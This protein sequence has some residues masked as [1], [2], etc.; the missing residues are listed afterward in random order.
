MIAIFLSKKHKKIVIILI[1]SPIPI[2][3]I[4]KSIAINWIIKVILIVTNQHLK[5]NTI[6]FNLQSKQTTTDSHI[7]YLF[8]LLTLLIVLFKPK[9]KMSCNSLEKT[10]SIKDWLKQALHAK[11]IHKLIKI[12]IVIQT[13]LQGKL[14]KP[15]ELIL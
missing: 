4:K 7:V 8:Q 6:S 14:C 3:Q 1:V 12:K 11:R 10:P 5:N 13:P 2:K 15:V 9:L